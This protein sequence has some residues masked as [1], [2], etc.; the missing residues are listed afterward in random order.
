MITRML[1]FTAL[2]Y[3]KLLDIYPDNRSW[4][5]ALWSPFYTLQR[6]QRY[7]HFLSLAAALQ[8]DCRLFER[9][10]V[11]ACF[12]YFC[13]LAGICMQ[14]LYYNGLMHDED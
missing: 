12:G 8:I 1:Y 7:I 9:L 6:I 14:L 4:P 13:T 11:R 10:R 5:A 2:P 3:F